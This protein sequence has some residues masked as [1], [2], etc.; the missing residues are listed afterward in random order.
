MKWT[1]YT[2]EQAEEWDCVVH[3]FSN[4]DVYYLSNYVRAFQ[5]HGD[6][7]PLLLFYEDSQV[8]GVNVAMKRDIA[9]DPHFSGALEKG[10]WF[11]LATPYGYGSW[12]I[13]G[14]GDRASLFRV[15]EDWCRQHR[16]VSEFARFHPVLK[17]YENMEPF[18]EVRLLG[19]SITLN[20]S[21]PEEIWANF[22]SANRNKIRKARKNGV[23]IYQGRY[24][25]LYETFRTIYNSTMDKDHAKE[26]YYFSPAF[27]ESIL[28]DLRQHAQI[29]YAEKDGQIIAAS[30]ML[31]ANGHMHYHL[32]G[33]IREYQ[34]LAPTN[35]LLYEAALW[36]CA[37]G[38]KTLHLGGGVG[39]KEDNLYM[40]KKAFY[41]GAPTQYYCG[42]K[43]FLPDVSEMLCG[44][45]GE[46][47]DSTYFPPYRA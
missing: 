26:Y 32:S 24:P 13:Q 8:R 35:L 18:Y 12:L 2:L 43:L 28:Y 37:N 30:I 15:Y 47:S 29:F 34:H 4:Y 3:S 6:G 36:G 21:S 39:E 22:A 31:F 9:D 45:R 7:E 16:I 1:I 19:N 27:Y 40:F 46:L 23:Q 41:R 14:E 10:V 33:S 20:L 25:S 11:D 38:Y 5:L 17:T 44:M 42:K